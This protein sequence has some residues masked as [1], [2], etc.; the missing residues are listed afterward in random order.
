MIVLGFIL[1]IA[2]LVWIPGRRWG[3]LDTIAV[4]AILIG[5]AYIFLIRYRRRW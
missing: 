5:N 2:F 3:A 1:G 4:A